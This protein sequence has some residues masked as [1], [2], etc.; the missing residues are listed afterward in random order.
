MIK[1][2]KQYIKIRKIR[3]K[4]SIELDY[5]PADQLLNDLYLS[6]E[7]LIDK[8]NKIIIA[9]LSIFILIIIIGGVVLWL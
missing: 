7:D 5:N 6:C 1:F 2:F 3:K 8:A 4:L 9:F